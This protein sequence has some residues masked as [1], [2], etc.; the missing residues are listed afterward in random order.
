MRISIEC[1]FQ[2]KGSYQE[3]ERVFH[4]ACKVQCKDHVN[5][6]VCEFGCF[7]QRSWIPFW[8]SILFLDA[9][10]L[11][12]S[13]KLSIKLFHHNSEPPHIRSIFFPGKK[14]QDRNWQQQQVVGK[15][16][17]LQVLSIGFFKKP[18][19]LAWSWHQGPRLI[20][21]W[22]LASIYLVLTLIQPLVLNWHHLTW[23]PGRC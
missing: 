23:L 22:Y 8:C 21:G 1:V 15:Y 12:L 6:Q 18:F 11:F 17:L 5:C 4:H 2:A 10:Q 14:R 13:S 7:L 20:F 19:I 3:I 9:L 16:Q